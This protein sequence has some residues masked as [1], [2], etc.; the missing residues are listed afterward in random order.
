MGFAANARADS[1]MPT[2]SW[3]APTDCP[4]SS[5]VQRRVRSA[6]ADTRSAV[7][8]VDARVAREQTR[9]TLQLTLEEGG[10]RRAQ[11]LQGASCDELVEA[12]IWL[13]V[14]AGQAPE[15]TPSAPVAIA[16]RRSPYLLLGGGVWS[17]SLP[18]PQALML[19]AV[20]Y[21]LGAFELELRY[22]HA[23]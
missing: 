19:G 8:R 9:Y 12:M 21:S 5:E 11:T 17:D 13:L 14:V 10:A 18:A 16:P 7:T 1:D 2:L 4:A 20:G 15:P 3:S 22:G 23:F 6:L